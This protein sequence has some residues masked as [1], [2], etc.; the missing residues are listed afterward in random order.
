MLSTAA[1]DYSNIEITLGILI[2]K[3]NKQLF[4]LF[5]NFEK[6]RITILLLNFIT[7]CKN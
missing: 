5:Y 2:A 7:C 1:L 6:Y 4:N 3:K